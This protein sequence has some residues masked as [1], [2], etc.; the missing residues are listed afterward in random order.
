MLLNLDEYDKVEGEI[1]KITNKINN[2]SYVGQTRSHRLNHAKYRPFG[3][4]GRFKDHVSESMSNKKNQSRYLNS[5]LLKYGNEN[6][7]CEKIHTC[8]V[9]ELDTY[10]RH[11]ILEYE[12]KYPNGYNLTDGGQIRGSLKGSKILLNENELV[13]PIVKEKRDLKRSDYTKS[14][15]SERLI[16]FKSDPNVR[17]SQMETT[18]RQHFNAKFDRFKNVLIEKENIEKYIF[19]INNYTLNYQYVRVV[20]DKV[21]T[22]FI[23]KHENIENIKDRAKTFIQEL[24]KWQCDQ[25]AGTPL[26]PS[27]PL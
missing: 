7:I 16:A 4:L 8:K 1:Y 24:I 12:T 17:K 18:Q 27:L 13:K 20:I 21:K 6:F 22:N 3:F 25:I 19:V 11:Y 26:E 15:I 23:G 2:K 14:L 5:A 9:D 10:E